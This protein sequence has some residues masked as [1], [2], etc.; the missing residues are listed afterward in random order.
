M[1]HDDRPDWLVALVC[2][3]I[4]L[5]VALTFAKVARLDYPSAW[6]SL[7]ADLLGRLDTGGPVIAR[8]VYLMLH[9]ILKELSSK[10][11]VA[12][13]RNFAQVGRVWDS[14]TS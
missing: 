6:P 2:P 4:A 12:D 8:R 10:R 3:Q 5:Q 11:L 1:P 7:F 13:Q 9:H 14:K